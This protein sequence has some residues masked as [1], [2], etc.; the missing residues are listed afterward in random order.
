MSARMEQERRE[1]MTEAHLKIDKRKCKKS[2]AL[3]NKISLK[4]VNAI[5]G[6]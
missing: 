4:D 2:G 5:D 6:A 1:K 3:T